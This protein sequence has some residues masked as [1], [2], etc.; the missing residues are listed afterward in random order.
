ME[1]IQKALD[2]A[3][4]QRQGAATRQ[5]P[6]PATPLRQ[7]VPP[8]PPV[9]EDSSQDDITYSQTRVMP[10]AEEVLLENRVIAG[11]KDHPQ[12]DHF[13]MLRTKVLHRMRQQG[14]TSLAITSP[15]K[16]GG[17]SMVAANLAISIAMEAN[18]TVLLVDLDLRRPSIHQYFGF[19]PGQGISDYL[20]DNVDLPELLV[21][22]NIERLVILPVGHAVAQSS[23]LL[24]TPRMAD[25]VQDI[26]NRYASRII[27]FDLP[28]LLH[29][30]DALAF[31]PQVD[32]SLLVSEE[33]VNTPA[34]VEQCMRLLENANLLGVVHN[35][36][37]N[38]KHS[39][40]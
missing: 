27:L 9:A 17:K 35:K 20:L 38:V 8:V 3:R 14:F 32:A 11:I 21:H 18:H 6:P 7:P 34:E 37:L 1:R 31:L 33:Q 29:M 2:K 22:P 28:P 40:Y 16:G 39:P 10:V 19:E 5:E 12:A 25:L 15:A 30:D 13:R 24:S 36:A 4:Q 26:T 23:E